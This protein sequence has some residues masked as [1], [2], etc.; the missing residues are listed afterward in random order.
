MYNIYISDLIG[1]AFIAYLEKTGN[2]T[3][4]LSK[5]EAYGD[6]VIYSLEKAGIEARLVLSRS[7]TRQFFFNYSDWFTLR[8]DDVVVLSSKVS[9]EQLINMFCGVESIAEIKAL[10][11]EKNISVLF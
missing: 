10:R 4:T 9:R 3:L 8:D 7:L 6:K 11:D 1:N 5:I 2:R